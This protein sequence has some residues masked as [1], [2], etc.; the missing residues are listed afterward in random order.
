MNQYRVYHIESGQFA[1]FSD[2]EARNDVLALGEARK[3]TGDGRSELWS[4]SRMVA[5]IKRQ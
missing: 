2:F 5:E 1:R 4:G 3:L